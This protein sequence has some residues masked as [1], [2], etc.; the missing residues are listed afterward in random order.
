MPLKITRYISRYLIR[1]V[2]HIY[3]IAIWQI[4]IQPNNGSGDGFQFECRAVF[5]DI[6]V[7]GFPLSFKGDFLA[8]K[9]PSADRIFLLRSHREWSSEATLHRTKD[10]HRL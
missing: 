7:P 9:L 2:N 1:C 4:F 8:H 10:Y 3:R 5:E 6:C